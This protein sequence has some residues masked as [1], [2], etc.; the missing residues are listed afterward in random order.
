MVFYVLGNGF[1][2]HYKLQTQYSDFKRFLHNTGCKDLIEKADDLFSRYGFSPEEVQNW[3]ALEDMLTVFARLDPDEIYDEAMEN[4]E[5]DDDRAAYWDSPSFNV[6]YYSE[7]IAILKQKFES[8]IAG[9]DTHIIRDAYFDPKHDD[10]IL[11]FNYTRT[12]EDN[13]PKT[14]YKIE[15]IHGMA[16][17]CVV[18]GHNE[19]QEPSY[20]KNVW[21]EDYDYRTS[22]ALEA[23]NGVIEEASRLYY[24]DSE[25]IILQN[26]SL[27][28][29]I[30]QFEKVVIMG[31][32]CG[33][34]DRLYVNE[35]L[36]RTKVVDFYYY[37]PDDLDRF[38][39]LANA[40]P[41]QVNG[42]RW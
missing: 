35:I 22:S 42:Y 10:A 21:D 14:G 15:H 18:L 29:T 37:A 24:K 33:K 27:F 16:G 34:Q 4:A 39:C 17:R 13:F 6:G 36:K 28:Q 7:Y 3:S 11:S 9:M 5:T 41:V 12:V 8:W 32:S 23:V 1:D 2:L 26:K 25:A 40:Y 38:L 31:L 19:H 30:C 20:Y